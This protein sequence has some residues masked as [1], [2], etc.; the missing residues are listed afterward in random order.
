MQWMMQWISNNSAALTV[1]LNGGMLLVWLFYAQLLLSNYRRARR[2]KLILDQGTGRGLNSLCLMANMSSEAVFI[3]VVIAALYNQEDRISRDITDVKVR[4]RSEE[5]SSSEGVSGR[6]A[7]TIQGP[8][9]SGSY[10]DLGTFGEILDSV[11]HKR[12]DPRDGERDRYADQYALEL[13]V[14]ITFGPENQPI[15]F[16]RCFE[17]SRSETGEHLVRATTIDTHRLAG[18][19]DRRQMR[20]WLQQYL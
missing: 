13:T 12:E 11:T 1:L 19:R 17:F 10:L 3:Q 14:I 4:A 5:D 6:Q 20:R 7:Q 8:L 2:A 9:Q 16:R 15:G 18:P